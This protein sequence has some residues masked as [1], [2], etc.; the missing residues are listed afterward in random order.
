M[1]QPEQA[2][3]LRRFSKD[4]LMNLLRKSLVLAVA[5]GVV[6][7]WLLGG[8]SV[9]QPAAP[10]VRPSTTPPPPAPTAPPSTS[11]A[12][13]PS[14][15][16]APPPAGADLGR[17]DLNAYC[18]HVG[19]DASKSLNNTAYGWVCYTDSRM[20]AVNVTDACRW[21]YGLRAVGQYG[22]YNNPNSWQ[23]WSTA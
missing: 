22:D 7:V 21:Q 4:G 6:S 23:C 18:R 14:L 3:G 1:N 10:P 20:A 16:G 15:Q 11:A 17:V 8:C 2:Y 5:A 12:P 13:A 9:L 19:Y